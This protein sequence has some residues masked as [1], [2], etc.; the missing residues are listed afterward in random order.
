M[1]TLQRRT[2]V[3]KIPA[4]KAAADAKTASR[5]RAFARELTFK[6][7]QER[8]AGWLTLSRLVWRRP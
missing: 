3:R 8:R 4:Y 7:F 2:S 6:E 1:S 5:R